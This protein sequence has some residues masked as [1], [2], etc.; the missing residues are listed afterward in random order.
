MYGEQARFFEDEIRPHLRH[1]K[2]G[3][4]AMA[5]M[6]LHVSHAWLPHDPL[7]LLVMLVPQ[8]PQCPFKHWQC[9]LLKV[10]VRT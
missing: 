1:K 2:K 10:G 9:V 6:F 7:N 5:G 4:V 3:M 8:P